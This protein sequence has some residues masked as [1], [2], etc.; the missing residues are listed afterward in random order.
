MKLNDATLTDE[1]YVLGEKRFRDEG[2]AKLSVGKK[3]HVLLKAE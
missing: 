2:V 3:K 1:R